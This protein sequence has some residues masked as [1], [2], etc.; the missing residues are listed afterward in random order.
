MD[1][2]ELEFQ[3][4]YDAYQ[5]RI[6]G[7]LVRLVGEYEAEDLTQEVFVKVNQALANF[8]GEAKLSTWI[9][10]I[11][12]NT[13]LDRLRS[14]SFRK[15]LSDD[16]IENGE[17]E[18]DDKDAW[19]GEKKPLVEQQLVRMEMNQC[20]RDFIDKLPE[21]YRPVLVLSELEG[22][23]NKEIAEILGVSLG[24]V[25]IRIHRARE[26]LKE[27][28]TLH[29]DSYWIEDNEFV[30]DLKRALGEFREAH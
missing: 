8:R 19:T 18:I 15:R 12:T 27:E 22:K 2:S 9:Y 4:I 14:P 17:A 5:P 7:Y 11:A 28:L 1:D 25:K 23:S 24:T 30:P 16:S 21:N 3:K 20:I 29:C 26:K 6:L 10:R 13:A